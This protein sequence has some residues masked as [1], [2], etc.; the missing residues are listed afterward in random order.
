MSSHGFVGDVLI[1][2]GVI[3][4]AG[5]AR[6][7]EAQARQA[8]TLGLALAGLGLADESAVASAV[9]SALHLEFLGGTPPA[10]ATAVVA[11]L[12]EAFCRRHAVAPL[13][14]SGGVL[15]VAVTN[16]MDYSILQDVEFRVGK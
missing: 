7:V 16:P 13:A 12:P 1:R 5:L 15:R 2:N 11:L 10:V 3:D 6:G 8:T 14:L 4:E 9:A